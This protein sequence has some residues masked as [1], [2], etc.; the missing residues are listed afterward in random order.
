MDQFLNAGIVV[1]MISNDASPR[2]IF[3]PGNTS[4]TT[5]V[6]IYGHVSH[7]AFCFGL[8]GV[9]ISF[10]LLTTSIGRVPTRLYL[11]SAKQLFG[12]HPADKLEH[13]T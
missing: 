12:C 9:S 10:V 6:D 13:V 4:V 11:Q 5:H 8:V 2:G 7:F 3:A 1:P